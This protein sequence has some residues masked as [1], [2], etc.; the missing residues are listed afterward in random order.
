MFNLKQINSIAVWNVNTYE[1][2]NVV[3]CGNFNKALTKNG[4][5]TVDFFSQ[6][7][8]KNICIKI[9][10][11]KMWKSTKKKNNKF[12]RTHTHGQV[13]SAKFSYTMGFI[14]CN[15][16]F[17]CVVSLYGIEKFRISHILVEQKKGKCQT[18]IFLNGFSSYSY[19][20]LFHQRWSFYVSV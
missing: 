8:F 2:W 9:T 3:I 17:Y 12:K 15:Q 20:L 10:Q 13:N 16:Y 14:Y 18:L 19:F 11:T 6:F 5:T 7:K 4:T 1:I